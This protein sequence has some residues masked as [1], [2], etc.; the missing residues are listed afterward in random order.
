[1]VEHL[2]GITVPRAV[3]AHRQWVRMDRVPLVV[4]EVLALLLLFLEHQQLMLV[5]GEVAVNQTHLVREALAV[6]EVVGLERP[7]LHIVRQ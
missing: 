3:L 1:M 7:A 4:L 6:L 2:M 5:E